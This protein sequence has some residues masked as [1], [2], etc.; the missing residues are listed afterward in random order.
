[1]LKNIRNAIPRLPMDRHWNSNFQTLKKVQNLSKTTPC[2]QKAG[3]G[4]VNRG[5]VN[6]DVYF[7][8]DAY[9]E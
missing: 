5:I 1:M 9:S 4:A 2:C 8:A 7:V 3:Y 6:D